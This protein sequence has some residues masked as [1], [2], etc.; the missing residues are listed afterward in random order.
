MRRAVR[1]SIFSAC[2]WHVAV[3]PQKGSHLTLGI[4]GCGPTRKP[5]IL[6]REGGLRNGGGAGTD[7]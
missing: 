5:M 2:R 4:A 6:A 7:L 1:D 3:Q